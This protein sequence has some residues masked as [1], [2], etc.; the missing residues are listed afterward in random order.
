MNCS[1]SQSWLRPRSVWREWLRKCVCVQ[2]IQQSRL[3]THGQTIYLLIFLQLC[4]VDLSDL[5]EFSS[6][7]GMFDGVVCGSTRGHCRGCSSCRSAAFLWPGHALC[8]QHIVQAHELGVWRILL[9]GTTN[10]ETCSNT[11]KENKG[12]A[13]AI[14]EQAVWCRTETDQRICWVCVMW[15]FHLQVWSDCLLLRSRVAVA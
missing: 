9:L 10:A 11:H 2:K 15:L 6:V 5:S 12:S 8:Q 4:V 13:R 3:K 14:Q 7:V 1:A